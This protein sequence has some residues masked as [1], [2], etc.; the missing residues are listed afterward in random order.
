MIIVSTKPG[1][2]PRIEYANAACVLEN[3]AIAA[4]SLDINNIIHGGA[5]GVAAQNEELKK[6]LEIP[7]GFNTILCASFGYA[8]KKTPAKKH[9][10]SVNKV[11]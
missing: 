4:T 11:N 8:T 1:M 7:E 5:S 3:M 2:M 6:Q 10:K 9:E